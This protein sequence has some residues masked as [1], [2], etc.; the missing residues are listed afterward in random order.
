MLNGLNAHTYFYFSESLYFWF[1]FSYVREH[2]E[3]IGTYSRSH[4]L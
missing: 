4:D 3:H 1:Y 2:N